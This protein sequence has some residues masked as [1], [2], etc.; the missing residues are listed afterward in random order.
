MCVD[1]KHC[2]IILVDSCRWKAYP[3]ILVDI[4]RWKALHKEITAP[5]S[6]LIFVDGNHCAIILV[7]I[8]RWKSLRHH[9]G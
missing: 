3:I 1:G 8:C 5:S 7:D 9:L 2:A 4:C 6:W